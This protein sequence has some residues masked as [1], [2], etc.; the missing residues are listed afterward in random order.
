M[1]APAE[2]SS[3]FAEAMTSARTPEASTFSHTA[4]RSAITCGAIE[5]IRPLPSH[6]MATSPRVSSLTVSPGCSSSGC[7]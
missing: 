2:N 5:F 4:P 7:A 1:S 6:A 3:G